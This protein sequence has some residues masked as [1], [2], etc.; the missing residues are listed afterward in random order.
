[1]VV[2]CL[3]FVLISA[4]VFGTEHHSLRFERIT[5]EDGL[6][7]NSVICM[8]RDSRGWIWFGTE[9]GLNRYNGYD[10]KVFR[11][12]PRD[13]HSLATGYV[14][15]ILE[16]SSGTLWVGTRGGGLNRF[17]A[18]QEHFT[19][20]V[21][22]PG[23]SES[24]SGHNVNA[25]V[26][27]GDGSLWVATESGLNRLN[28]ASGRFQRYPDDRE[29]SNSLAGKVVNTL[30][31]D[32]SSTLWVGTSRG[33]FRFEPETDRFRPFQ[34]VVAGRMAPS[35]E[36]VRFIYED[37]RGYLWIATY[38][39]GLLRID[40]D[41]LSIVRYLHNRKAPY[42]L[43]TND[44]NIILEDSEKAGHLWLGTR[45]AGL[46]HFDTE[47][48]RFCRHRNVPADPYSISN[49]RVSSLLYDQSG[50][51]WAGTYDA[52]INKLHR[53]HR[54]F[55]HYTHRPD[56][57][58][59]LSDSYIR[60]I[61]EDASGNLWIGTYDGGLNRMDAETRKVTR[62]LNDPENSLSLSTNEIRSVYVD[63]EGFVWAGTYHGG[64][65]RLDPAKG[66]FRRYRHD[67]N[68][69]ES[70]CDDR[71][72]AVVEDKAGR[73]W[74]GTEGGLC[75]LDR[76][77]GKFNRFQ[78]DPADPHSLGHNIVYELYV[79]RSG[80]LWI[81]T[82][83]GG[84]SRWDESQRRFQQ[85]VHQPGDGGSLPGNFVLSLYQ[86]RAGT[87]WV[88][89]LGGGL[90]GL[91]PGGSK[92][93]SFS[94][95]DGLPNNVIHGI[96]EDDEGILWLS[97]NQGLAR[98]NPAGGEIRTYT[99]ADGLLTNEFSAKAYA[100]TQVENLAFGTVAGLTIFDPKELA[101]NP[102]LPPVVI[103]DFQIFN[104]SVVPAG[105]SLL[106]KPAYLSKGIT[107]SHRQSVFT[108]EFA[109]LDF[110]APQKNQYAYRMEGFDDDWNYVENR[111]FATYTNLDPGD[112][113]FQVKASN[114][115]GV[116]NEEGTTIRIRIT[117]PFWR[118]GWAYFL[119]LSA[120]GSIFFAVRRFEMNRIH[121][122][123]QVKL[124]RLEAEK[125]KEVD[126]LKSRFFA[127]ISH[128]FRT[129]LTLI[130][131]PVKDL[132]EELPRSEWMAKLR[133]VERNGIRLRRLIDQ[134]LD[135]SRMETGRMR[136]R[137]AP[138][139]IVAFARGVTMAF[140]SMAERARIE[141]SFQSN[142]ESAELYFDPEK[143]EDVL[144]NLLSNAFKFTPD[145]GRIT[146]CVEILQ[147][148]A[149]LS[150]EDS[151]T[152]VPAESL[153]HIFK[154]FYQAD[155]S[156]T[157][158]PEGSGIGLALA[159][160]LVRLHGGTIEAS[161]ETGKGS[162]F[163]VRLPLGKAHLKPDE[164]VEPLPA[165]KTDLPLEL[166][167]TQDET[168]LSNGE[169][170]SP[171]EIDS[172]P[173]LLL[174]ED[175]SDLRAF[176]R[177][178]LRQEYSLLEAC[179]GIEGLEIARSRI[180]DLVICDIM[181]PRMNG[182][183]FCTALKNDEL[184]S[185]IPVILLTARASQDEKLAGLDAGADAYLTKPFNRWEL[186]A[187][188]RNLIELRRQLRKRFSGAVVLK[189]DELEVSSV[190]GI[191]LNKALVAVEKHLDEEAFGVAELAHELAMSRSQLHRKLK[192]LTSL[193]PTLF[194]RSIRLQRAADLLSQRAGTV[195]EIAYQVGFSS[196]SYFSKCFHQEFGRTPSE[197]GR[198]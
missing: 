133:L 48:A 51:L 106:K 77:Q 181:M 146:T 83:G 166:F 6:S 175:N 157:R 2:R 82:F 185:H 128:E 12:D 75:E 56:D 15:A 45:G 3:L 35:R 47:E 142:S 138:A 131:G 95:A 187:R 8:A 125:L 5:V 149:I 42:P 190:D 90:A 94:T 23:D 163:Q 19:H 92:F 33:L 4:P 136:L 148:C 143:L 110:V 129:P 135:L 102:H 127:N 113:L 170:D 111:R 158:E 73:L 58:T 16:D 26:E 151:G 54:R 72:L 156:E 155:N 126:R 76:K 60:S 65:N 168:A 134:L 41:R 46:V 79:D 14:T 1:M 67:P 112:Y 62:F 59:S 103:T 104:K 107:L 21:H 186:L 85:F 137:A 11:H 52:G 184:T 162:V 183:Q 140:S 139:D 98:F 116:W 27:S 109:A 32:G 57:T 34:E 61:S 68:D 169:P 50:T 38:K 70:L 172:Q 165:G 89:T 193:S 20:F 173:I 71:V 160:E 180:P 159:Q 178:H 40:R 174:V 96:L 141:L 115:D 154:R 189:L 25:I 44:I 118:T 108:F 87:L 196:Q 17:E 192:A 39:G 97:S 117:P 167:Q 152:G 132:I 7:Q 177:G 84:L 198:S 88:G 101:D 121:L 197:Y 80:T 9:D 37:N 18:E 10:F 145:G 29:T 119:Y 49:D 195:A 31:E 81:A 30:L 43:G 171:A 164:I 179:D 28:R 188:I 91:E 150:V 74:V 53:N 66:T 36:D 99:L 176:M 100:R 78:H 86:D 22:D 122:R 194:I 24:L 63:R 114:S 161:S 182:Y 191:F 153:P 147:D 130:L 64:L 120:A 93:T 105:D 144:V 123:N 69:P 124:G 55:L 13:P